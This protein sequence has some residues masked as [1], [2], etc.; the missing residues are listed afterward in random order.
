MTGGLEPRRRDDGKELFYP[1]D[2]SRNAKLIAVPI[3][4]APPPAAGTPKELFTVP[5]IAG[6]DNT[7]HYVPTADGQRFL[8][9]AVDESSQV[10]NS[11]TVLANWVSSLKK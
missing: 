4:W 11:I 2:Q 9:V 6:M 3:E 10:Q 8:T 1:S 5:A 7:N